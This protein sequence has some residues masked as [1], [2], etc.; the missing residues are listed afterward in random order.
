M[1]SGNGKEVPGLQAAAKTAKLHY[2]SDTKPGIARVRT[3]SGFRYR[4]PD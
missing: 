1:T 2:A 4:S 3:S